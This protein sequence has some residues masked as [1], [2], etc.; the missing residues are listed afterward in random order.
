MGGVLNYPGNVMSFRKLKNPQMME[1]KKTNRN[2][3][4]QLPAAQASEEK[5]VR[6]FLVRTFKAQMWAVSAGNKKS[7]EYVAVVRCR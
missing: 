2:C 4:K 5:K 6:D 3:W 1:I 7:K